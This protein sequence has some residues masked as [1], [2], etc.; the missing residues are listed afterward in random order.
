M[1]PTRSSSSNRSI[2]ADPAHLIVGQLIELPEDA[3]GIRPRGT[4]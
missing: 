4:R 1:P 2:L 3:R